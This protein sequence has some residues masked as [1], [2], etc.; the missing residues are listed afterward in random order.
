MLRGPCRLC[1]LLVSSPE[2]GNEAGTAGS[3]WAKI[4]EPTVIWPA[5]IF[6]VTQYGDVTLEIN[7]Q[8]GGLG[9][10]LFSFCQRTSAFDKSCFFSWNAVQSDM[11]FRLRRL[12]VQVSGESKYLV[13]LARQRF[14]PFGTGLYFNQELQIALIKGGAFSS[15]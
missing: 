7:I 8:N 11:I 15:K 2:I 1:K 13:S 14:T 9:V 12:H 10:N 6:H 5:V 3:K 4:S